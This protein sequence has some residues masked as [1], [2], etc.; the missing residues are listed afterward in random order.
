MVDVDLDTVYAPSGNIV[1]RLIEGEIIIVPLVAGI[2]DLDELF[3]VND[4]GKAIWDKLDGRTT[5]DHIV[6]LLSEEF[7][8]PRETIERDVRGFIGELL[9][10]KMI[11]DV[12]TGS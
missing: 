8:A 7:D 9:R 12:R 11:V 2:G 5:L 6:S 10:R 3:S 4:C 1:A